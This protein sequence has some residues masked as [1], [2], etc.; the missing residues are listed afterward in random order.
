M[1]LKVDYE[2]ISNVKTSIDLQRANFDEFYEALKNTIYSLPDYWEG[3]AADGYIQQ[4]SDLSSSFEAIV[5]LLYDL[6][7]QLS[8]ISTNFA[9]NDSGMASQ[10]GAS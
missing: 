5:T 1:I 7:T 6:S 9:S 8:N 3:N 4:F 2:G 10:L